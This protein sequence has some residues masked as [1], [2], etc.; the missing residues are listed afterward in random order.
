M[1]IIRLQVTKKTLW[2]MIPF[3]ILIARNCMGIE[4]RVRWLWSNSRQ[5]LRSNLNHSLFLKSKN[6]K[7]KATTKTPWI[8]FKSLMKEKDKYNISISMSAILKTNSHCTRNNQKGY[9]Q[10][11]QEHQ[12]NST[13]KILRSFKS[14][15][16][17][18]LICI[19]RF[20]TWK[21]KIRCWPISYNQ[22]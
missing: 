8:W 21:D 15:K 17:S 11:V 13:S 6:S 22:V 4:D 19:H 5:L 9:L 2:R 20:T 14:N 16:T 1:L 12:E 7:C 18:L 10:R 3:S